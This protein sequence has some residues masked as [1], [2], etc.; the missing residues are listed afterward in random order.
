MPREGFDEGQDARSRIAW[1]FRCRVSGADMSAG[2]C[3]KKASREMLGGK[4]P[5][6]MVKRG[7]GCDRM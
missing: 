3:M 2:G 5:D 4:E 7:E 1:L 6:A